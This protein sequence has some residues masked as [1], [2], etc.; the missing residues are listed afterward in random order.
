[1]ADASLVFNILARN[2]TA[3]GLDEAKS[4]FSSF[5]D[6]MKGILGS[7]IV[8]QI[9]EFFSSSIEAADSASKVAAQT[10]TILAATGDAAG[11]TAA[12]VATLSDKYGELAGVTG[13]SVQNSLNFILRNQGVQ[14][15]I[16]SNVISANQLTETLT[17][18]AATMSHGGST[19]D[20]LTAASTSLSTAL[21]NPFNATKALKAAGDTLTLGQTQ[22]LA[23]FKKAGDSAG[24][25]KLVLGSLQQAT[26][27]AAA[28][29]TTP[30]QKLGAQFDDLKIK[31]G[32][33]LMPIV[34]TF[35]NDLLKLAPVVSQVGGAIKTFIGFI[36]S[37][38]AIF[39]SVA[40]AILLVVGGMRLWKLGIE[41]VE[42]AQRA[43]N[44][45]A[46]ANPWVIAITAVIAVLIYLMTQFSSVR[47]VVVDVVQDILRVLGDLAQ[48]IV[49][50]VVGSVEVL[51]HTLGEIPIIGGPF[52][53]AANDVD[54]FRT[55][56]DNAISAVQN[57]D[58]AAGLTDISSFL[59]SMTNIG[60]S[61]GASAA[62]GA[63]A[64]FSDA[65]P[66]ALGA[67]APKAA[68]A[69]ETLAQKVQD[70]LTKFK[71]GIV[72]SFGSMGSVIS[73]AVAGPPGSNFLVGNLQQQL[74]KA[75]QFVTDISTL[76]H[77]GL[78]A[79]SLNELIAAGPD[80]GSDAA[81]QLATSG[82][83]SIAQV[84]SLE[85]QF[86]TVGNAFATQTAN[87]EFGSTSAALKRNQVYLNFDMTGVSTDDFVKAL[88]KAIRVKGGNVQTVLGGA[89]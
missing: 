1:M 88:R 77:A 5:G 87:D 28:A 37:N 69:V 36:G 85:S 75:K 14:Q 78:N 89:F 16:G 59:K 13:E 50:T 10:S 39:G 22:Q 29:N 79:T 26:A 66:A 32:Q 47:T 53:T 61:G 49:N 23:A 20:S 7:E 12:Q 58:V 73:A 82:L 56:V 60:S 84:N 48:F 67:A 81:R 64:G 35:A 65:L 70:A 8:N 74:N 27:G 25:Y 51:L 34:T 83:G 45:L 86:N 33:Q 43:L 11:L 18:L 54:A 76:R 17:D 9:G 62:T 80:Q 57:L 38:I 4:S 55:T 46:E 15:A 44:L 63:A 52:K 24:A 6:V 19:A 41:A 2:E 30:L 21:A 3:A 31:V 42:G 71:N 40:G 72:Q 68:A